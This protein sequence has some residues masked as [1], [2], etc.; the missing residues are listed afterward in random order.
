M[1]GCLEAAR[2]LALQGLGGYGLEG[3]SPGLYESGL[4]PGHQALGSVGAAE[5]RPRDLKALKVLGFNLRGV[6]V[7]GR[8]DGGAREL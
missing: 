5:V 7:S 4:R 6:E 1:R 2:G 8:H 3:R